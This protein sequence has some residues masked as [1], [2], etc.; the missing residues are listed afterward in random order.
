MRGNLPLTLTVLSP[1]TE[2]WNLA[3]LR[4]TQS[5]WMAL[6]A[7]H[8]THT[9][10]LEEPGRSHPARPRAWAAGRPQVLKLAGTSRGLLCAQGDRA[11]GCVSG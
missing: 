4:V 10:H 6:E 2:K 9:Q 8:K 11:E 3:S 1:W 5:L 7:P